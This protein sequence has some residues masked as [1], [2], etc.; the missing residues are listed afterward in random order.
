MNRNT[1]KIFCDQLMC[2][3]F[4]EKRITHGIGIITAHTRS[5]REGNVFSLSVHRWGGPVQCQVRCGRGG[6]V[7]TLTYIGTPPPP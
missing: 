5:V 1:L 2:N 6:G 3:V 4:A 7:G